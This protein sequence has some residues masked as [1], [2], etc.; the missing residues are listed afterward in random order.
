MLDFVENLYKSSLSLLISQL[1]YLF[2]DFGA[3]ISKKK[4]YLNNRYLSI[5]KTNPLESERK[6]AEMNVS[7]VI[8]FRLQGF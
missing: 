6:V 7:A 8:G 2:R 4:S 5:K 1:S 3:Q